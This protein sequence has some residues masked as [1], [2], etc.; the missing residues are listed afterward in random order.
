MKPRTLAKIALEYIYNDEFIFKNDEYKFEAITQMNRLMSMNHCKE[1]EAENNPSDPIVELH[2][3][4]NV[5]KFDYPIIPKTA[6]GSTEIWQ[7]NDKFMLPGNNSHVLL[8][9]S[10]TGEKY[11]MNNVWNFLPYK[12]CILKVDSITSLKRAA[13]VFTD[14]L[15]QILRKR[16]NCD[17]ILRTQLDVIKE[18]YKKIVKTDIDDKRQK[19]LY[20][21]WLMEY[22]EIYKKVPNSYM[23]LLNK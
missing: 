5:P 17:D 12:S 22:R 8:G 13:W 4:L 16:E 23:R 1:L 3:C 15:C 20:V 18:E 10:I 11:Y 9:K 7:E 19:A 6:W 14:N 21:Q 2:I